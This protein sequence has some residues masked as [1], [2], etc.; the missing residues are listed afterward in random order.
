MQSRDRYELSRRIDEMSKS[1][2]LQHNERQSAARKINRLNRIIELESQSKLTI[3]DA[4]R[5]AEL[6]TPWQTTE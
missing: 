6:I 2:H 3:S 4:I 1:P 5:T